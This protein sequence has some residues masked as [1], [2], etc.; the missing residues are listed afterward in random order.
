MNTER[1][2]PTVVFRRCSDTRYRNIG[3][4]GIVVRQRASEV[5]VVTDVGARVLDLLDGATP[6][7]V[8]L[9]ALG[10]EYDVDPSTLEIDTEGYL[11]DLLEAGVIEPVAPLVDGE[12]PDI[13]RNTRS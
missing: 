10:A 2:A 13:S 12:A 3:G 8:L 5:L 6:V 9:T 4:E 11:R 1:I 7:S